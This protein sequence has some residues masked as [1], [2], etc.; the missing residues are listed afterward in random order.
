MTVD[1]VLAEARLQQSGALAD[2]RWGVLES[3]GK[4][5]FIKKS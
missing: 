5:S 2:V 4:V 1:E 3:N